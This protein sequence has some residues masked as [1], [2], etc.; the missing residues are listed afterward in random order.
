MGKSIEVVLS[1]SFMVLF[2]SFCCLEVSL[3]IGSISLEYIG[4]TMGNKIRDY[5]IHYKQIHLAFTKKSWW[6]AA[7][8]I[9]FDRLQYYSVPSSDKINEIGKM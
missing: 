5:P 8:I 9:T 3:S 7:L 1:S 4:E 6:R 2:P